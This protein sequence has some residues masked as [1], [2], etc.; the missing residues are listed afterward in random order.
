MH[1]LR[2]FMFLAI[3]ACVHFYKLVIF[4]VSFLFYFYG[5]K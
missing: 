2:A 3:S 1:L 4:A 5:A